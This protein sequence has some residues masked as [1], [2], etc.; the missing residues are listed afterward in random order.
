MDVLLSFAMNSIYLLWLGKHS[1]INEDKCNEGYW[2]SHVFLC[3]VMKFYVIAKL[4][5]FSLCSWGVY[6]FCKYASLYICINWEIH[7]FVD[8]RLINFI[9]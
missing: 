2:Q 7:S 4:Q 1:H 6:S 9:V 8:K 3:H 5:G